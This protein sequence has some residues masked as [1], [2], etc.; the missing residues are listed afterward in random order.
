MHVWTP[1]LHLNI[2]H[3]LFR[4]VCVC[5]Y[6]FLQENCF[7]NTEERPEKMAFQRPKWLNITA[8]RYL[9]YEYR[10]TTRIKYLTSQRSE[11]IP[12]QYK[13]AGRDLL[14]ENIRATRKIGNSPQKI[15]QIQWICTTAE[16]NMHY[17]NRRTS[18]KIVF[19]SQEGDPMQRL[20]ISAD[21]D[22]LN[23]NRRATR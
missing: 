23:K 14:C 6:V 17:E 20:Y 22:L 19:T 11:H 13:S 21:R 8:E 3:T 18:R 7:T 1:S 4:Y 16:R 2:T 5:R 15:D 9:H 10:R 12:R